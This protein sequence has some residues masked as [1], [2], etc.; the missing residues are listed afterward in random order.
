MKT[1]MIASALAL[2][3]ST[4]AMAAD[5][6]NTGVDLVL[7]RDNLTFGIETTAGE[8]TALS[9]GVAVLPHSVLGADADVTLGAE[10]GIQ[11]EDLTF[12][13][14][15]GLTK[16]Y[17]ALAV[18]GSLEASYTIASG[19]AEGA[20]TATPTVGASY[21]VNEKLTAFGDV[22]YDFDASNDWARQGGAVEIGA[23]YALNDDIA[24][25]PSLVRTFDTGADETN[26]NIA[27]ALRF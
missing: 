5:F 22:S 25:T 13:A 7:E 21:D 14:A 27:V 16:R 18:Y 15:Y 2:S 23:R 12:S 8:A 10:Y 24:L 3:V 17:D 26:L 1:L 9:L 20:W 6:D 19:A 11:T 4:A